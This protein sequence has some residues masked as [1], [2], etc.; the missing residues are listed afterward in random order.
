[1]ITHC[2]VIAFLCVDT[3]RD[4]VTLTFDLLTLSCMAGHVTNPA[5]KSE[6]PTTIRSWVSSYNG[7]PWLPLKMRTRP[8]RMRRVTW[9]V[10]RGSKIIT[11]LESPTPVCLF[12]VQLLLGY[13]DDISSTS[14]LIVNF[15][16]KFGKFLL[17]WQQ[18][19]SERSLTATI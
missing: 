1:M 13:D 11:F 7:S 19:S 9:P 4:L 17:L 15:L 8:L 16:L 10:N 2:R 3:S 6:D 14:K 5:T 12:T 18:G